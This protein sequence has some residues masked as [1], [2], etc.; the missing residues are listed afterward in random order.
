MGNAQACEA[1]AGNSRL[2]R[3]FAAAVDWGPTAVF[4]IVYHGQGLLPA[5]AALM[6][7]TVVA[8]A[9][10]WRRSRRVPVLPCLAVVLVLVFGGTALWLR[11]ELF[12]KTIP[13]IIKSS[14]AAVLLVAYV[15]DLPVLRYAIGSQM[16]SITAHSW[17]LLT[18]R[19][20][21]FFACLAGLNEVIWRS[22]PT[23]IWVVYNS[24]GDL[25]LLGLFILGQVPFVR[26][27]LLAAPPEA[28]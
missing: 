3:W 22:Q 8:F 20:A 10:S 24:F 19:Y 27:H 14:F 7:A 21:V 6:A 11:S 5:T 4:L 25:A 13:T 9:L 28:P 1:K 12:V 18:L 15:T 26:R 17:R 16:P 2:S 23:D